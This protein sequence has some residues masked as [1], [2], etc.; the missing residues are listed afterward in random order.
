LSNRKKEIRT[1]II[2]PTKPLGGLENCV[3]LHAALELGEG[4]RL[5]HLDTKYNPIVRKAKILKVIY[6]YGVL[7][8]K[9]KRIIRDEQIDIVHIHSTSFKNVFKNIEIQEKV[10][11]LGAKSIIHIHGGYFDRFYK[12]LSQVWRKRLEWGLNRSDALICLSEGWKKF[13][14]S[15]FRQAK[16]YVL[17]NAIDLEPFLE[18]GEFR[19]YKKKDEIN[20]IYLGRINK[21]KGIFDLV[22]VSKQLHAGNVKVKFILAGRAESGELSKLRWMLRDKNLQDQFDLVGEVTGFKRDELFRKADCFILPSHAE[23]MPIT[24]LEAFA[25]GL[26]VVA[27]RVGAVPE[28]IQHT[29][30]GLLVDPGDANGI[31]AALSRLAASS[32]LREQLGKAGLEDAKN[33]FSADRWVEELRMIYTEVAGAE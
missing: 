4:F 13:F 11:K 1:L 32:E 30:N 6:L 8:P 19:E 10:K 23:G 22:D 5:Y 25:L 29:V 14:A 27:T 7:L 28:V 26:P 33:R 15:T 16:V 2:G 17:E 24:V 3:I 20:A 21:M 12:G 9:M 18:I 31:A